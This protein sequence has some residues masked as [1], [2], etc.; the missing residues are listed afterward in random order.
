MSA[1]PSMI[2]IVVR[3][4]LGRYPLPSPLTALVR[5]HP[6]RPNYVET[7]V[8]EGGRRRSH[9]TQMLYRLGQRS[10]EGQVMRSRKAESRDEF[11]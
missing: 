9:R 6:E 5:H 7:V 10:F 1:T 11:R 2:H 4:P 8:V 3:L